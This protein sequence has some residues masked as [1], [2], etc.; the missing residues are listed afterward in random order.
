MIFRDVCLQYKGRITHNKTIGFGKTSSRPIHTRI[1]RRLHS[2]P[3]VADKA[4]SE[5]GPRG[6]GVFLLLA[7]ITGVTA[8]VSSH[9]RKNN[10]R[11]DSC[12]CPIDHP[13][14]LDHLRLPGQTCIAYRSCYRVG[15]MGPAR[16]STC[17]LCSI[18]TLLYA[19]YLKTAD[20]YIYS[21]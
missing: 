14:P 19:P 20:R 2:H 8:H 1:A 13:S 3:P 15:A 10:T 7:C 11:H 17:F 6:G 16:S 18:C 21:T 9:T 5:I 12:T 4:Y